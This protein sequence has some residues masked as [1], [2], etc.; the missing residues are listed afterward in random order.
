MSVT[1]DTLRAALQLR[2]MVD[3][4]VDAATGDMA[5]AWARLWNELS[6]DW[7]IAV[8]QIISTRSTG[9]LTKAQLFRLTRVRSALSVS[10]EALGQ[11][12]DQAESIMVT[13]VPTLVA[14][15]SDAELEV[16]VSQLPDAFGGR[17]ALDSATGRAITAI[18][19]RATEQVTSLTK[20]LAGDAYQVMLAELQRGVAL[21][22]NPRIAANRM[23]QRT[24]GGFDGGLVRA[25]RI[26]RTEMLDAYRAAAQS[27]DE[28]NTDVLA[29]WRWSASLS[30]RTC[31]ACLAMNGQEFPT[32]TPG[33][34][35]HVNCRCARTP[36]AKS[37]AALGFVGMTE[38]TDQWPDSRAW[39]DDLTEREQ[40]A[41]MGPTRLR[42]L[43]SGQV[44]WEDLAVKVANTGWRHSWQPRTLGDLRSRATK[45]A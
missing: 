10:L 1:Q 15:A 31:P 33:P 18:T 2:K 36:V 16:I 20:P 12:A 40:L 38:P 45:T 42:L 27:A 13:R 6:K 30:P 3:D 39:F 44:S 29:G 19:R 23:L 5:R 22:V 32:S 7:A 11:L 37:W 21:G 9:R 24:R 34:Q 26:A 17:D 35:G 28:A 43:R 41:I 25:T 4:H 8:D 14:E